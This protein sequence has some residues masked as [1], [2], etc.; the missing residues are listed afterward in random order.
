MKLNPILCFLSVITLLVTSCQPEI[1]GRENDNELW[2]YEKQLI[3]KGND[4]PVKEYNEAIEKAISMRVPWVYSPV[5]IAL[6]IAGQQMVS[7]EVNVA[8]R[9]LSESN[10][11]T[12]VVVMVEKKDVKEGA[13]KNQYYRIELKL[14]GSIWQVTQINNAWTCK[15]G[16]GSQNLTSKQ[17]K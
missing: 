13:I 3:E 8:S 2:K 16:K 11:I 17:C 4:I 6:R 5:S 15:E 10:L 7:T 12:H 1:E 14:G 9:S